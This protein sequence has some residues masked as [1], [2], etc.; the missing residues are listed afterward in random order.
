VKHISQTI[1]NFIEIEW[2][3]ILLFK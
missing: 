1:I 3:R 2:D